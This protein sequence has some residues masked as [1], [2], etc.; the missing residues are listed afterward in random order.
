M[1]YL[2]LQITVLL[3]NFT[4]LPAGE[5]FSPLHLARFRLDSWKDEAIVRHAR[6]I[7]HLAFSLL[8]PHHR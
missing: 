3:E 1:K 4:T 7:H 8:S 2:G 5:D 6:H